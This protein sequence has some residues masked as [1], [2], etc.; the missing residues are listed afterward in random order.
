M[1]AANGAGLEIDLGTNGSNT[2]TYDSGND[3]MVFNK[4]VQATV[5]MV[6]LLR[7]VMLT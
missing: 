6:K 1:S 4:D 7:H 3:R 2:M 5:F